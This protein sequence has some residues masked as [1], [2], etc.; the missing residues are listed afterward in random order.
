MQA[1]NNLQRW[2]KMKQ[3]LVNV[4]ANNNTCFAIAIIS[5]L[6]PTQTNSNRQN[7][8][9]YPDFRKHLNF[10]GISFS[11]VLKVSLNLKSNIRQFQ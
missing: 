11:V 3:T 7:L 1:I 5:A 9:N 4:K 8:G 10:E 2:I 6:F